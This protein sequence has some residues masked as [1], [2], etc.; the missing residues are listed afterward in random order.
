MDIVLENC[1]AGETEEYC[2]YDT[3]V[4]HKLRQSSIR[5]MAPNR[6]NSN[7]WVNKLCV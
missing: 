7:L 4:N 3:K 5:H 6:L 1:D 2:L